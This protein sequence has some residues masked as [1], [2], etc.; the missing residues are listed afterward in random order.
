MTNYIFLTVQLGMR[1]TGLY[2][3]A[4]AAFISSKKILEFITGKT[5]SNTNIIKED[6][7]L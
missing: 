2:Y 3:A 6:H 1:S 7:I 4:A 5:S